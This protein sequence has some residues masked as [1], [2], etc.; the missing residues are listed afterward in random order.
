MDV[1]EYKN[2]NMG[3]R[4]SIYIM[5]IKSKYMNLDHIYSILQ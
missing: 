2:V 4:M 5:G 1:Y 3:G